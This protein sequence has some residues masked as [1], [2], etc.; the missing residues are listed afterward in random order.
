MIRIACAL[1]GLLFF[2]SCSNKEQETPSG[3]KFKVVK[4]GEGPAPKVHDIVVFQYTLKDSKDS[5]WHSTY[6]R[7]MPDA[8]RVEDSTSL[9]SEDGLR[10]MFRMVSKGDS[11]HVDMPVTKFFKDLFQ[12]PVPP[13]ID[14]TLNLSFRFKV[15]NIMSMEE[16]Q[17]FQVTLMENKM[18]GQKSRDEK[19]ITDYLDKNSI[20]AQ[21][22]TS[23][24][25]Y[26]IHEAKGGKKPS[27]ANCVEVSYRGSSLDTQAVFDEN[28]SVSFPLSGVI[29]GWRVGIPL[30]GIGDSATLYIPS[31]MGYG[32]RGIPGTIAPDAILVFNVRLKGIGE[33]Y[34]PQT[35]SC[36]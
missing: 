32:P 13:E 28:P 3:L 26:V 34:D 22:D 7:G 18:K 8:M 21:R 30:L 29:E 5:L 27:D 19:K 10:Q 1:A 36:K 25:H 2:A 12:Q 15:D 9:S 11:V 14:S 33:N 16:F 24:L 4:Q 17:E 20:S 6:E 23:G 35:R 31:G